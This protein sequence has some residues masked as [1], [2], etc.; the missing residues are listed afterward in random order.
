VPG[1]R[2]KPLRWTLRAA[3]DLLFIE[4]HYAEFG[5]STADRVIASIL[6]AA[7]LLERYPRI[8]TRG[9]RPRTRH[10]IVTGYPYTIVYRIRR[11]EI[12]LLRVLH[13]S[14]RFFN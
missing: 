5:Q 9:K 12:Q 11:I 3:R 2:R 6:S 13:Q 1:S 4:R 8:G 7:K 14:R 10:R